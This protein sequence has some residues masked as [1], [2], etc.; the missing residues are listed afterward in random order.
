MSDELR[1]RAALE[2]VDELDAIVVRRFPSANPSQAVV[3]ANG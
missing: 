2:S 3:A 1:I